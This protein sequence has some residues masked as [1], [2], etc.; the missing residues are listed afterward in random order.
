MKDVIRKFI[1]YEIH[2]INNNSYDAIF[3]RLIILI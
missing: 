1:K 2:Q 3:N